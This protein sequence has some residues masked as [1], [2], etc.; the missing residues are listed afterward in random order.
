MFNPGFLL[1]FMNRT[2]A[3]LL[4]VLLLHTASLWAQSK[5]PPC[6]RPDY[7]KNTH[8]ERFAHWHNCFGRYRA[9]LNDKNKGD[10]YEG[11]FQNGEFN[12]KGTYTSANG[13]KYIGE[14]K[15]GKYDGRG[16]YQFADGDKYTGEYREGKFNGQG[17]YT[18][19]NA[20][21]Y[22]GEFKDGSFHGYGTYYHNNPGENKGD[23][24]VGEFRSG[25]YQGQG[26]YTFVNGN[27]FVG[28]FHENL[29]NGMGNFNFINGDKYVGEF[30][31]WSRQGKGIMIFADGSKQEGHWDKDKFVRA[32]RLNIPL[33]SAGGTDNERRQLEAERQ[34]LALE[35]QRLEQERSRREA[36]RQTTRLA[37]DVRVT[38]PDSTGVVTITVSTGADTSSLT[39]DDEEQGG[40]A[41]GRYQIRKIARVG[42]V[43]NFTIT[44]IDINGN[45]DSKT[46][47]VSRKLSDSSPNYAR[48]NPA[49]VKPQPSRDSV[50]IIIG[51]QNYKRIPRAEYASDDAQVFYDYAIRALGI[52][53][54][55]IKLLLDDGADEVDILA[56]FRN[57]LPMKIRKNKT[58]LV[59]F[60]SGHGLPS[61][62]GKSLYLLPYNAHRELIEETAINQNKIVS[63][64][65]AAQPRSVTMFID[66]CYSGQARSGE[67]LIA[68]ARPLSMKSTAGSYPEGFTVITASQ[69]DQISW[70]S[71]N[72]KHGIFSFYVMKGLEGDADDNKDGKITVGELQNY[73]SDMVPRQA[74][75]MSRKQT[76]QLVGDTERVLVGR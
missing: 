20:S 70:S 72:L 15:D 64:I 68:S 21:K 39:I 69:P 17:T 76:P 59:V 46:I 2:I 9:E 31:G 6:P 47:T 73:L 38:E 34:Q 32:E 26:T 52:K 51:I 19:A 7:S 33:P 12:G 45:K 49:N 67:M 13:E 36:A 1:F 14:Y 41:D 53:P 50:A 54:E 56:A 10:V 35:R 75:S 48:L 37:L 18:F 25:K 22:A 28:E 29:P 42:Q 8:N 65:Q 43:T 5:L 3:V 63:A 44:A 27:K 57:W 66:A 55:N 40:R 61:D 60:Y 58:D 74:L 71:P 4:W 16:S 62:D 30:K 23:R 24:Y 11:E